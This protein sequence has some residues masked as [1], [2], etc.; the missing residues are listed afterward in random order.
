MLSNKSFSRLFLV[1]LCLVAFDVVGVGQ[2][3]DDSPSVPSSG[4]E[5]LP[6]VRCESVPFEG[7]YAV[8]GTDSE[9]RSAPYALIRKLSG[10]RPQTTLSPF[11]FTYTGLSAKSGAE[12]EP[13]SKE[14]RFLG[15]STYCTRPVLSPSWSATMQVFLSDTLYTLERPNGT[16]VHF[17]TCTLHWVDP[18]SENRESNM[19]VDFDPSTTTFGIGGDT[20]R[21]YRVVARLR[22][23]HSLDRH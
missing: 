3:N 19:I 11:S 2:A 4:T 8:T 12:C 21:E 23:L 7:V 15:G 22:Y 18:V 17:R 5:T 14:V 1:G 10:P 9:R 16:R 6:N 13:N 20:P